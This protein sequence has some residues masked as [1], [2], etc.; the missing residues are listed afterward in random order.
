MANT[1][2]REISVRQLMLARFCTHSALTTADLRQRAEAMRSED[3]KHK[4]L[5]KDVA[6][7]LLKDDQKKAAAQ[8]QEKIATRS[9]SEQKTIIRKARKL[10]EARLAGLEEG[11]DLEMG[12]QQRWLDTETGWTIL[13]QPS[14]VEVLTDEEGDYVRVLGWT[15]RHYVKYWQMEMARTFGLLQFIQE[16]GEFRIKMVMK[17]LLKGDTLWEETLDSPE[18]A[19]EMLKEVRTT[20]AKLED[21]LV[22]DRVPQRTAGKHCFGCPVRLACRQGQKFLTKLETRQAA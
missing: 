10:V 16:Q 15:D 12:V 11:D 1:Q 8:V 2:N 22:S 20:I 6:R 17:S 18:V 7:S 21:A 4:R 14:R 13:F 19:L 3:L 9:L 5:V